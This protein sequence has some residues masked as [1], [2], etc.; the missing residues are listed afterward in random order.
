[1]T[2]HVTGSMA[3]HV[4]GSFVFAVVSSS[5]NDVACNRVNEAAFGMVVN[6]HKQN[7]ACDRVV[8]HRALGT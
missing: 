3:P 8:N 2:S 7:A 6:R 4:T 1:M 5:C